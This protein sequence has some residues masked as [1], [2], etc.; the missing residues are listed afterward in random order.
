MRRETARQARNNV[1]LRWDRVLPY[2]WRSE[3]VNQRTVRHRE[4]KNR[5][6]RREHPQ[7]RT[8]PRRTDERANHRR[9]QEQREVGYAE[10]LLD[11]EIIGGNRGESRD[12]RARQRERPELLPS[13]TYYQ[14]LDSPAERESSTSL[15]SGGPLVDP[16]DL[17]P[18]QGRVTV[19]GCARTWRL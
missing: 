9:G 19:A 13:R 6:R 11:A 12:R 10:Q 2:Q 7:Q 4:R 17:S 5:Q 16:P 14:S 3:G 1:Y 8:K 15:G 18:R